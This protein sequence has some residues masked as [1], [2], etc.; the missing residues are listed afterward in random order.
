MNAK[1]TA[2]ANATPPQPPA[3]T[4]AEKNKEKQWIFAFK[5]KGNTVELRSKYELNIDM[6]FNNFPVI[7]YQGNEMPLT[8]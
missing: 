2:D 6:F 8:K 7:I 5:R 4:K 3:R 1:A